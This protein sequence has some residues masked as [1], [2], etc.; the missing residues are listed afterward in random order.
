MNKDQLLSAIAQA[1][2]DAAYG[3]KLSFASYDMHRFCPGIL[4][5][6]TGSVGILGLVMESFGN[7]TVAATMSCLGFLTF[8]VTAREAKL[9][10]LKNSGMALTHV[11][12][13]L[14]VLYLGVAG[15]NMTTFSNEVAELQR[16][17]TKITEES[18]SEQL[19]FSG[20]YAHTKL[21]GEMRTK[22]I[23][24]G[25]GLTFWKDMVPSTF[26]VTLYVLLGGYLVWLFYWGAIIIREKAIIMRKTSAESVE[27]AVQKS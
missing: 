14:E 8:L 20:W 27:R 6:I 25:C 13:E 5:L 21:F 22:W 4:G 1:G 10:K 15:S 3:A 7:K 24:D 23:V 2:Y 26:K 18:V 11:R 16:L 17:R 12:N 19:M 9:D